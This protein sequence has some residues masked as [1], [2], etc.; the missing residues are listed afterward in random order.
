MSDLLLPA[1]S[2][3]RHFDLVSADKNA[4]LIRGRCMIDTA[5][6]Q[7]WGRAYIYNI[8]TAGWVFI[9]LSE[10][11]QLCNINQQRMSL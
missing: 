5:R 4:V 10:K 2:P 6:R 3:G 9:V 11:H 8:T 7:R 1:A